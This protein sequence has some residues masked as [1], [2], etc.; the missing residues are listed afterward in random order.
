MIMNPIEQY[1]KLKQEYPDY[2]WTP[3]DNELLE[4]LKDI[5]K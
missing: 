5:R 2:D 3:Y 4:F 1:E